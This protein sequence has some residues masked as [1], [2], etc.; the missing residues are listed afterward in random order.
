MKNWKFPHCGSIY[1]LYMYQIGKEDT[2]R[3][4]K[5]KT[6]SRFTTFCTQNDDVLAATL[7]SLESP[8][9][10]KWSAM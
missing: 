8:E 1:D 6:V 3:V 10:N 5:Q 2:L 7:S 9:L 4:G